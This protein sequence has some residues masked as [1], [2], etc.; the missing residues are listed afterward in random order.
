VW[1][2]PAAVAVVKLTVATPL[3]FVVELVAASEPPPVFVQPTTS[4]DVE[5][6][7]PFASASC[8]VIVTAAP[9]A[10]EAAELVT[11]YFEAALATVV[12]LALVPVRLEPSVAVKA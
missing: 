7:L 3:A 4:P 5:T 11:R 8:A 1:V 10:G 2:V 12:E 6:E 9:A